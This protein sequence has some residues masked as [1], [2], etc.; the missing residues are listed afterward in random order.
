MI[1]VFLSD[2]PKYRRTFF[3]YMI[4]RVIKFF[5]SAFFC[6]SLLMVSTL[7]ARSQIN[8]PFHSEY[9]YLKGKDAAGLPSEWKDPAFDDS[10]WQHG[11]APFRY[12]DG[13]YGVELTDMPNNYTTVYL[14]SSFYCSSPDRLID[15]VFTVDYDDGFIVWVNGS[16]A[17]R[18][19]APA[20]PAYNSVAPLNHESGEGEDFVVYMGSLELNE[21]ENVIAVQAFNVS[22]SSSDFYF[23]ISVFAEEHLPEIADSIG[24]HFSVPSGYYTDPFDVVLTSPDPSRRIVYTLDGSNPQTSENVISGNS[25]LVVRVDPAS[26]QGRALTPGVVIR[27]S[28]AEEGY[29]PSKPSSGTYLFMEKIKS[30]AWPGGDWPVSTVNDQLIDLDMDRDVVENPVYSSLIDDALLDLPSISIT[31][32]P[33]NL[34]DPLTGIYVNADGH[35]TSWEKECSVELINPDGSPGFSVNAGLRIRGGW[36]RH[37][38]FPK[39]SFRLFFREKY[40]T[41][42]LR[43]P[44]FGDEGASVFDKIDLRSEQNYAWSTG[45]SLN[46]MVREIFSRDTQRDMGRPYT[47]S[48]YYHL[49]INGMYWGL[50]IPLI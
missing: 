16:E 3:N 5:Y 37:G 33:G 42:K 18:S 7:S 32:G 31:T 38:D 41:D 11:S 23:D 24:I 25:P 30:Q 1:S 21:G 40:G 36:S 26:V 10:A 9:T 47:R 19:N 8:F 27:A 15:V 20:S 43:F 34:F 46:S 44:L 48:R 14:R 45:S 39:H 29:R 4:V 50:Y 6:F 2:S 13:A 35:G 12:G 22:S 17:L 49:Y 28:Q